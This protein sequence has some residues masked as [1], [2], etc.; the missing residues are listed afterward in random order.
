MTPRAD[1]GSVVS[2]SHENLGTR[3]TTKSQGIRRASAASRTR[4]V[5]GPMG[6]PVGVGVGRLVRGVV[7]YRQRGPWATWHPRRAARCPGRRGGEPTGP[8]H[9]SMGRSGIG[10]RRGGR[11]PWPGRGGGRPPCGAE[12]A[13]SRRRGAGKECAGTCGAATGP[14]QRGRRPDPR[15]NELVGLRRHRRPVHGGQRVVG[16]PGRTGLRA[17]TS[18]GDV[19]RNRRLLR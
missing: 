10:E 3:R 8:H 5:D 18:L 13:D 2:P 12:R 19:D 11:G 14:A 1:K 4:R 15:H 9:R 7:I 17:H 6:G 16:G